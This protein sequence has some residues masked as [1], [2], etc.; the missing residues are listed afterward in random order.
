M[1][2][3]NEIAKTKS[4]SLIVESFSRQNSIAQGPFG[5][6]RKEE[7]VDSREDRPK[8]K[9]PNNEVDFEGIVSIMNQ[10]IGNG[11]SILGFF[12]N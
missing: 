7:D 8:H 1:S 2:H 12:I 9:S 6:R 4:K 11:T 10:S 5:G 3:S